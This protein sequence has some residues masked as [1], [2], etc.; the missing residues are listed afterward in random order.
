M[1]KNWKFA[2]ISHSKS[3]NL[4]WFVAAF[5]VEFMSIAGTGYKLIIRIIQNKYMVQSAT[6][7]KNNANEYQIESVSVFKVECILIRLLKFMTIS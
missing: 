3:L 2:F 7:K 1:R 5:A 4:V 6:L